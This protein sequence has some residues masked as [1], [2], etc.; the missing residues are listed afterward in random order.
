MSN[1]RITELPALTSLDNDDLLA[2]VDVSAKVTTKTTYG[3][4][5]NNIT[6][7]IPSGLGA[8]GLGWAR[9]DDSTYT[10][11]SFLTV[12]GSQIVL[13][14]DGEGFYEESFMNSS[15]SFY[16]TGSGKIQMEN[17]GDVYS[18][19]ITFKAKTP[20]ANQTTFDVSL[21]STGATP[22]D[23]VSKTLIFAKGN[24][25]WENFYESFH[26]YADSDF[27]SNG[28]QWKIQAIGGEVDV[29]DIIYFI[30]RTFNSGG[31]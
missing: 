9:Y 19:V 6:G 1:K 10:T 27:V 29:A 8:T 25:V 5:I 31:E 24:E 4:L 15:V 17:V 13:P 12:T 18:I 7:S 26:F 23:R 3:S 11:S 28:N 2:V 20:N 22:Y 30:Q 14:N 21:T 16:N